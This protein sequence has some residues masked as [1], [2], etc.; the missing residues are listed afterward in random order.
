MRPLRRILYSLYDR[1]AV[2]TREAH[3]KETGNQ[4]RGSA[5]I[6]RGGAPWLIAC[7]VLLAIDPL[8]A[9]GAA[10][11]YPVAP[12]VAEL[13][14]LMLAGK[15]G[16]EI[17]TRLQQPAVLGELVAGIV[18]GNL[19]IGGF[20]PFQA[21][22]TDETLEIFAGIG[23]LVL[24]F[25]VGVESTVAQMLKVGVTALLVAVLGV[26]APF[27]LGWGVGAWLLPDASFYVHAFL[28]A[29]LCAT[30][31]GITAR[32]L[33]DLGSSRSP[34]ARIILGAAVIDDVLGLVILGAVAGAITAASQGVPFSVASVAKTT[35]AA[36]I[37]LVAAL[38]IGVTTAPRLFRMASLLQV[39]GVLVTV[40]LCLCFLLAWA[41][42]LIGLA[43][44]IGAFAA[45][46]VLEDVL[47]KDFVD[48][49]ERTLEELL[50][51]ISD[52]LVPIFFVLMGLRTDLSVFAAPGALGLAAA[53]I[54]AAIIGK[55][56]CSLGVMTP[57][58]NRLAVGIGMVPRGEV[59]LIFAN[60]GAGLT[61]NGMPVINASTFSA[62]VAMVVVT[63]MVTPPVLKWS[64]RSRQR[65]SQG[66]SEGRPLRT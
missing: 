36:G 20:A 54:V 8:A 2:P 18:L 52:I 7:L 10:H 3:Q 40:S 44:I 27:V 64:L 30:S 28:G 29:T 35:A 63:T 5:G 24:L 26:V 39:R 4:T 19:S 17:A 14:V 43:P 55:Q 42:S 21:L 62:V 38:V 31:V 48:R 58:V 22:A 34:E 47:F 9:A 49:G 65:E 66:R 12:V 13:A 1:I 16:G 6:S 50:R 23:A 33:Q 51:P 59:G 53:L 61:L 46:L 32:V 25:E 11:A 45:G 56:V 41:A 37:F 57:G 60:V 15:V